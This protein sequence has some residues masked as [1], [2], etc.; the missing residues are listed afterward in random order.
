VAVDH[1]RDGLTYHSSPALDTAER[2]ETMERDPDRE[3]ILGVVCALNARGGGIITRDDLA[4]A[5]QA[6]ADV[7]GRRPVDLDELPDAMYADGEIE[8]FGHPEQISPGRKA[9][10]A[11]LLRHGVTDAELGTE[12]REQWGWCVG[13]QPCDGCGNPCCVTRA[14]ATTTGA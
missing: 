12:T 2:I 11:H 7:Y 10:W 4:G 1:R 3:L 14:P 6:V 5:Y 13:G 8:I 9:A